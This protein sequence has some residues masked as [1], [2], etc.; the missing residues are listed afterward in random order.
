MSKIYS[1]FYNKNNSPSLTISRKDF[2]KSLIVHKQIK[3]FS[4][5]L[6]QKNDRTLCI[7]GF[8]QL[9]PSILDEKYMFHLF[10]LITKK[11]GLKSN[12]LSTIITDQLSSAIIVKNFDLCEKILSLPFQSS[13]IS[14]PTYEI[15]QLIHQCSNTEQLIQCL[16]ILIEKNLPY[17]SEYLSWI[18]II[19][20]EH[21]LIGDEIIIEYILNTKKHINLLFTCYG[22]NN[23]TPLMLFLHLYSNN[24]CQ[25]LI[26]HY[27]SNIN[28]Q[29]ILLQCDKWNRSYLM[30]LLCGRCQ[31]ELEENSLEILS[32]DI[33]EINKQLINR[34]PHASAV[35]SKFSML[36]KLGNKCDTPI[37]TILTSEYC[38]SLRIILLNY[39]VEND[40]SIEFNL[41]DFFRNFPSKFIP[42]YSN[43]LKQLV[44]NRNLNSALVSLILNQRT[45]DPNFDDTIKFLLRQGARIN[46][47]NTVQDFIIYLLTSSSSM[48]PFMLL[49]YSLYIDLPFQTWLSRQTPRMS[50]YICRVIQCGYPS[51]FRTKFEEFKTH[52]PE[53]TVKLVVQFIDLK[54]PPRLSKLCLQKL[55]S[56]FKHLGDETIDQFKYYLPNQLRQSITL[57]GY[58]ECETYFRSVINQT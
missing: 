54:K 39:L 15:I 33:L 58:D 2:I 45:N 11:S 43:Y 7:E 27:L 18:L 14:L 21:Y 20:F 5:C 25:I 26:D 1:W 35:L 40:S 52:L 30:H 38:L 47:M 56:S 46:N 44:R 57:Y 50:L 53:Q 41:D 9:L 36:H 31:H 13:K 37:K 34:C 42:I 4:S 12:Q 8:F 24:K 10:E 51:E 29:L 23:V 19:L 6:R 22:N 17:D 16:S 55:R 32:D 48:I 49:D 3:E 28:D